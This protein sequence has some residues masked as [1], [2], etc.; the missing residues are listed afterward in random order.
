MQLQR[1][2]APGHLAGIVAVGADVEAD[3]EAAAFR[4][5]HDDAGAGLVVGRAQHAL[6]LEPELHAER[7]E[8]ARAVERDDADFAVGLVED[9][10]SRPFF[11]LSA[12]G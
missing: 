8:L 1:I 9:L 5:Q 10:R 4:A 12:A 3:A 6:H 7:I 11:L 2:V